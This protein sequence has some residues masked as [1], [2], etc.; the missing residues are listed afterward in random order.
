MPQETI[1]EETASQNAVA[2]EEIV[3]KARLAEEAARIKKR[4][5]ALQEEARKLTE[6]ADLLT[7]KARGL[8]SQVERASVRTAPPEEQAR[9][10]E[11]KKRAAERLVHGLFRDVLLGVTDGRLQLCET[12]ADLPPMLA[13]PC[14]PLTL[15]P[16]GGLQALRRLVRQ[17]A[18]GLGFS[19]ERWGDLVTA[20]QEAGMNAVVHC[21][22]GTVRLSTDSQKTVQVRVEDKGRGI[23]VERLPRALLQKGYSTAGT[24]GHGMKMMI[25]ASDRIWLLTSPTGTTVVLEQ[26]RAAPAPAW[27]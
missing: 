4:T 8:R 11:A 26:D 3:K 18:L 24:F 27:L 14:E 7:A 5:V 10:A 21:G 2:S 19:E 15:T 6:Q 23:E 25:S 20:S 1:S 9:R 22:G 12:A 16:E 17:E 13:L